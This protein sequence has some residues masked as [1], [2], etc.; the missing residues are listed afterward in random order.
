MSNRRGRDL[1]SLLRQVR[2]CKVCSDHLPLG[3]RPILQVGVM[4]RIVIIGQ[5]PGRRVH[6]SG[7]AWDDP[8]GD[9][10]RDWLGLTRA[11]F[12]DPDLVALLP[13]GFCYPGST[14]G[15]DKPPRPEC[16]PLWHSRLFAYLAEDRLEV[17]IGA[18]AQ[19][20]YIAERGTNLTTTVANWQRYLPGQI[21]LPHPSPRN[22]RWLASNPWFQLDTVPAVRARV[23]EIIVARA[24]AAPS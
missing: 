16:E 2:A 5:A 1:E 18:Y 17:V 15:G 24:P 12:Y 21:V 7:V 8:S 23:S 14:E 20:R 13:M 19:A 22:N 3:P 6:E 11:Q 10:L 9:R 4:P